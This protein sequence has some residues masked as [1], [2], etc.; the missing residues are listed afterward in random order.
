MKNSKKFL[1]FCLILGISIFICNSTKVE[2]FPSDRAQ[3]VVDLALKQKGKPYVYGASGPN[4]FDCSG[5]VYYCYQNALG[6]T[7]PRTTSDQIKTGKAISMNSLEPGD[8]IFPHSGHVQ[9]YVGNGQVIHAP[10]SGDVVKIAN[11]PSNTSSYVARRIE[12]WISTNGSWYFLQGG[13]YTSG[14]IWTNGHA[15]YLNPEN[16]QMM[17]GWIWV[18]GRSYYQDPTYGHTLYG[19]I[20][21]NEKYYYQETTYGHSLYGWQYIDG[22]WYYLDKTYGFMW[23][24]T[25][26]D[27][28]YIGSDGIAN[29]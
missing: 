13:E 22:H 21:V 12:G 19:W 8:L 5:L 28:Y 2:A 18:N 14:W 9:I 3:S 11:L 15:Y 27:G 4:S 26:V 16:Y 20:Y 10:N 1:L 24:N 29:R 6:V 23:T 17:T 25:Y 7:L